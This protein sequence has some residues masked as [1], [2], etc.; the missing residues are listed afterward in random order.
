MTQQRILIAILLVMLL[1]GGVDA[2]YG[3]R[4]DSTPLALTAPLTLCINFLCFLWYR[5]DSDV[6][7]YRRSPWLNVCVILLVFIGIPYYLLRSR[8]HGRK[9]IALAKCVGFGVLMVLADAVG[10]VLSGHP[11]S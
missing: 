4:D 6:T 3:A 5:R 11:M 10:R 8:P 7:G 1:A 2:T 9:L